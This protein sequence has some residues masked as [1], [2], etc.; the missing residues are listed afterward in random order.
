MSFS[1]PLFLF[2]FDKSFRWFVLIIICL[3]FLGC[4][5]NRCSIEPNDKMACYV[6]Q[7]RV[8]RELNTPYTAEN[9]FTYSEIKYNK[10]NH[11]YFIR[12][13]VKTEYINKNVETKYFEAFIEVN[14]NEYKGYDIMTF[15]LKKK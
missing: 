1:V 2:M 14:S 7:E 6:V 12:G 8:L 13:N 3:L 15:E 9:T 4:C 11:V 5:I 10:K